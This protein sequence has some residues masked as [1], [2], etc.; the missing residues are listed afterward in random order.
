MHSNPIDIGFELLWI[1]INYG[2][3][4]KI[5]KYAKKFGITGGTVLL[6]TGTIKNPILDFLELNEVRKEIVLMAAQKT[7]AYIALE[8]LNDKFNFDK[9]NHGI[10]FST[11]ITDIIGAHSLLN[12]EHD[13][14]E[15]RGVENPMYNL[16]MV[17]V[18]RGKAEFVVEAA[19]KAGSRG[20]TIINARGSGIH[21]TSKLFSME[22]EPEKEIVL[23]IA[24]NHLTEPIV[25]SIRERLEI[26]KPGKG[27]IFVQQ[28]NK[29]YG[30]IQ[31]NE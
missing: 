5:L 20:A 9:P 8:R 10:A 31:L 23:I 17:I 7:T 19:N 24:Q 18:D 4:S 27:I 15:S 30:L 21:D 13:P 26:D 3:G 28:V 29:T 2:K 22:I 14:E 1:I 6:G 16:I 25:S 12:L 11:S